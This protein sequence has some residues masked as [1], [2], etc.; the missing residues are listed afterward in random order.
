MAIKLSLDLNLK[1]VEDFPKFY[2]RFRQEVIEDSLDAPISTS[3]EQLKSELK[4]LVNNKVNSPQVSQNSVNP[5]APNQP[6]STSPLMSKS[7]EDILQYLTGADLRKHNPQNNHNVIDGSNIITGLHSKNNAGSNRMDL[8]IAINPFESIEEHY[9]RAL[10]VFQSSVFAFPNGNGDLDFFINN[11]EDLT[12]STKIDC[13]THTGFGDVEPAKGMSP[14]RRFELDKTKKGFATWTL[15]QHFVEKIRNEQTKFI[16]LNPV[17]QN[18]QNNDP[19]EAIRYLN[20]FKAS[21]ELTRVIEKVTDI[22]EGKEL[23]QDL[24]AYLSILG[25]IDTMKIQKRVTKQTIT[26]TLVSI[27]KTNKGTETKKFMDQIRTS[28]VLWSASNA[29]KWFKDMVAATVKL[30]REFEGGR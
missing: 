7:Q 23:P 10:S 3:L 9:N 18:I 16:N 14:A 17:I 30:I 4:S 24:N 27:D 8:Q 2:K 5:Q 29:A 26:Y 6:V 20:R 25:L 15:K 13:S 1:V 28:L 12:S 19:E 21:N 22:S 11:G